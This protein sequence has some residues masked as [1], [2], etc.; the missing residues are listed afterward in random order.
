[1]DVLVAQ[2]KAKGGDFPSCKD[3]NGPPAPPALQAAGQLVKGKCDELA[4]NAKQLAELRAP[5]QLLIAAAPKGQIATVHSELVSARTELAKQVTALKMTKKDLADAKEALDR[6]T[7]AAGKIDSTVEAGFKT[8]DDLLKT[9]DRG[10][11]VLGAPSPGAVL[12]AAE[13][14]KVSVRDVISAAG[15][16]PADPTQDTEAQKTARAITGIIV[17]LK[18]LEQAKRDTAPTLGELGIALAFAEGLE[19][20]AQTDMD[21]LTQEVAFL[22]EQEEALVREYELLVRAKVSLDQL[23]A[24]VGPDACP[25]YHG[26]GAFFRECKSV[27]ARLSAA[28][29]LSAYNLSW[30]SGQTA[31][32]LASNKQTQLNRAITLRHAEQAAVARTKILSLALTSAA[33]YGAGGIKPETIALFIQAL[34]TVAIAKGVN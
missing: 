24:L 27:P 19:A 20:I 5:V 33:N 10:A 9:A 11:D 30:A 16:L 17:G 3:F 23:T 4:E 34:A 21:A 12:A 7:Q 15:N 6:A 14:R 2:Y 18:T 26:F 31:A 28:R 13:F 25:G 29:A 32:R 1:L 22:Q 8:L